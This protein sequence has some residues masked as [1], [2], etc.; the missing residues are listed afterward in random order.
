MRKDIVRSADDSF[1]EQKPAN[2]LLV[3]PRCAHQN[4]GWPA[5]ESDLKRRF[6]GDVV[7]APAIGVAA[8]QDLDRIRSRFFDVDLYSYCRSG[9]TNPR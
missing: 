3:V 2:K 6:E 4:G 1:A 5:R 7:H 8:V 9:K